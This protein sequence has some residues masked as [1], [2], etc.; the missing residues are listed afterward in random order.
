MDEIPYTHVFVF[1]LSVHHS[2]SLP[3]WHCLTSSTSTVSLFL[4][5]RWCLE[6]MTLPTGMSIGRENFHF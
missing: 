3:S 2:F 6:E 4:V 1:H 5:G